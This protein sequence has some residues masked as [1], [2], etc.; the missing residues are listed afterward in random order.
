MQV[1]RFACDRCHGQKLRCPRPADGDL[2]E[3]CVRC[4]KAGTRCSISTPPRMGRPN[5]SRKLNTGEGAPSHTTS[6]KSKSVSRTK[7]LETRT[8]SESDPEDDQRG[9]RETTKALVD[10]TSRYSSASPTPCNKP[11]TSGTTTLSDVAE[12]ADPIVAYDFLQ[13]LD[14]DLEF[15]DAMDS[16]IYDDDMSRVIAKSRET[17]R[18]EQTYRLHTELT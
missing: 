7:T 16:D 9:N 2:H 1:K 10:Q 17:Y 5:K 4:C 6:S 15:G 13:Y 18:S 14:F 8:P 11:L 12:S 3:P